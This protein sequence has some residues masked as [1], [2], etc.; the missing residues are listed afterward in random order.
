MDREIQLAASDFDVKPR[1]FND[2][3]HYRTIVT[4]MRSGDR[5]LFES[6]GAATRSVGSEPQESNDTIR[7]HL[8]RI[9]DDVDVIQVLDLPFAGEQN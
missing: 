9:M 3:S 1:E 4:Q 6:D 7:N 5:I 2:E 8:E